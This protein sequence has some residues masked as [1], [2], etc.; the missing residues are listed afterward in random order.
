MN[1]RVTAFAWVGFI[2]IAGLM[3]T[4]LISPLY[5]IYKDLWNLQ[6][7]NVSLIYVIYM[8]GVL[9][10]LLFLG[11]LADRIYYRSIMQWGLALTLIG[12]FISMVAWDMYSLVTGR[13][14][15]GIASSLLTTSAS[16]GLTILAKAA[17]IHRVTMIISFLMALG[18]G[19]GPLLGGIFGQWIPH[20]LVTAYIPTLIF[21]SI[22]FFILT[23]LELP[24]AYKSS[25]KNPWLARDFLPKRHG[26][27]I[28]IPSPSY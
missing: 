22:C 21:C 27:I 13:F 28:K 2:L 7:S 19:L 5:G 25:L 6:T 17:K 14:I 18:F 11:R 12:T 1:S 8:G 3:S 20:P 4:A 24:N 9:F 26:Q 23:Q 15:V 16:L 10:S